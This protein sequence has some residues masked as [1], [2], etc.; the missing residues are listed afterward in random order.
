MK[1]TKRIFG[2]LKFEQNLR[3]ILFDFFRNFQN[4]LIFHKLKILCLRLRN[5]P[6]DASKWRVRR[7]VD[8]ILVA[9]VQQLVLGKKWMTLDLIH[10][11]PMFAHFKNR[12]YLG[13]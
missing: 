6:A 11:W 5:F 12:G 4:C 1:S 10:L 7:H 3:R 8:L 9:K 13:R 2:T